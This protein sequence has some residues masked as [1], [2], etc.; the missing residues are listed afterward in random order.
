M[1]IYKATN[2]ENGKYYI[3][4]TKG[5]LERRIQNHKSA[6]RNKDTLFY[7]AIN[8]Y[9]IESFEWEILVECSSKKELDTKEKELIAENTN[10]YNIAEG[11]EGGDTISN[12]PN[13]EELKKNVS[14]THK[15]KKLSEEHKRKI[16]EAHKGKK[17]PWASSTAK[18]M[19]E[20]NVGKPS[21]MKNKTHSEE[22]KKKMSEAHKGKTKVFTEEHKQNISKAKKGKTNSLKGKTYEEIMGVEAAKELKERQSKARKGRILKKRNN[23]TSNS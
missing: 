16:S 20:G 10:G 6:A 12:H 9:G 7:R 14:K 18:K 17:K 1:I 11:G 2:K 22:T 8:K 4:Q 23:G 5:T 3:G 15:G 19:S 13:L 21:G